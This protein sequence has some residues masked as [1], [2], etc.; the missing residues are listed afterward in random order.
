MGLLTRIDVDSLGGIELYSYTDQRWTEF[1]ILRPVP[2]FGDSLQQDPTHDED[3]IVRRRSKLNFTFSYG[4]GLFNHSTRTK[5]YDLPA[6]S[7]GL[8]L[9][10]LTNMKYNLTKNMSISGI[11][12]FSVSI[13]QDDKGLLN[14][15]FLGLNYDF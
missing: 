14:G 10:T 11:F 6:L 15:L 5:T 8:S 13:G 12:Q 2:L 7:S 1:S 4:A 3:I 9:I